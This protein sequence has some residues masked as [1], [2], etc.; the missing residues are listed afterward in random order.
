MGSFE[1]KH[2]PKD[3]GKDLRCVDAAAL[4]FAKTIL[5]FGRN[6]ALLVIAFVP[7]PT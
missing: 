5:G 6:P 7:T 4:Q 3:P 1:E 2:N